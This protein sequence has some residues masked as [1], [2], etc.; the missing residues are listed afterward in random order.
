MPATGKLTKWGNSLGMRI[1]KQIVDAHNFKDG[2]F[3][4]LVETPAGFAPKKCS[5]A[6]ATILKSSLP[7]LKTSPRRKSPT[8]A[9]L[10]AEKSGSAEAQ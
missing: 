6:G 10:L 4:S 9:N 7:T 3:L 5:G 8:G 2:E 1:P